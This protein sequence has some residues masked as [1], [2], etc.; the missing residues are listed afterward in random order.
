MTQTSET[1][2]SKSDT[3]EV[4]QQLKGKHVCPFCGV[5]RGD[6]AQPCPRCTMEDTLATRQGTRQRIGPW[7]VMQARNP[8]APGMKFA[9]L[10]TLVRKGHV[11]PRSIVRGPTTH[12]LW[13]FAAKVRGL[14][15][16]LGLCHH[17]GE[18]VEQTA[19]SCSACGRLQEPPADPDVLMENQSGLPE[20]NLTANTNPETN[21]DSGHTID[22][23]VST[24]VTG[25]TLSKS[26]RPPL[27]AISTPPT[28]IR[29]AQPARS[30]E[31]ILSAR[32]LAA[33]F[34][35]DFKPKKAGNSIAK[36]PPVA[37][38]VP[39]KPI[40]IAASDPE[41]RSSGAGQKVLLSLL[42]LLLAGGVAVALKPEW[43][44]KLKEMISSAKTALEQPAKSAPTNPTPT[45][46]TTPVAPRPEITKQEVKPIIPAQPVIT[47]PATQPTELIAEVK[48]E[49]VIEKK[50][51]PKSPP[52]TK[53]EPPKP[54]VDA[55]YNDSNLTLDQATA[56][57]KQL[58]NQAIDLEADSKYHEAMNIYQRIEKLPKD[59]HPLDIA[60]NI[61]RLQA[62]LK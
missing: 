52:A 39:A 46:K 17:C 27:P 48:S 53:V 24:D 40:D 37:A 54:V 19:A 4:R 38:P 42:L 62:K 14:S 13:T 2:F 30:E 5:I 50:E 26:G 25:L 45:A 32:E 15:R 31:S 9:T 11:T 59:A 47:K 43:Q 51:E 35:L 58:R 34:Q 23:I 29:P 20:L 1:S 56:L 6:P 10:V 49:P 41:E 57:A 16:E 12:Q 8:S 55:G 28:N 21:L 18:S 3:D 60:N 36:S 22:P 44:T 7:Y 61:K 33:A